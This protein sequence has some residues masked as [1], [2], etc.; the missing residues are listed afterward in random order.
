MDYDTMMIAGSILYEVIGFNWPNPSSS[1]MGLEQTQPLTDRNEYQE[2][3][4]GSGAA[5]RLTLATSPPCRF[6]RTDVFTA[7][8][9][10]HGVFWDVAS[11]GSSQKRR[12][13]RTCQLHL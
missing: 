7:V 12:F 13:G 9:M 3:S 11:C 2:P 10:K 4:R 1:F 5:G 6:V 8:G